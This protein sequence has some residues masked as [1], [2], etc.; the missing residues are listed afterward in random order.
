MRLKTAQLV[1][2][3]RNKLKIIE[4]LDL[5]RV[6]SRSVWNVNGTVCIDWVRFSF[7]HCR[8]N[9]ATANCW[10]ADACIPL[11]SPRHYASH[12]TNSTAATVQV[13]FF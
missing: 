1:H 10:R 6:E 11:I 8:L 7:K 5:A 2:H 4:P 13:F 9:P 3:D 12:K